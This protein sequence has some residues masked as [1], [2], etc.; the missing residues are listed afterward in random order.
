[1]ANSKNGQNSQ[2]DGNG[3]EAL[4][5]AKEDVGVALDKAKS[6]AGKA[7]EAQ[8]EIPKGI[9]S[10]DTQCRIRDILQELVISAKGSE[11]SN[12]KVEHA[13]QK[14]SEV[15]QEHV[16][17]LLKSLAKEGK[18]LQQ[19]IENLAGTIEEIP[20]NLEHV[21]H[22][23][24]S[25]AVRAARSAG[26]FLSAHFSHSHPL[27]PD[28]PAGTLGS[29]EIYHSAVPASSL[30]ELAN[31]KRLEEVQQQGGSATDRQFDPNY[32]PVEEICSSHSSP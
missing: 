22:G 2:S 31:P 1:L 28:L 7:E 13:L 21:V 9:I 26:S 18:S 29:R 6:V 19:I 24:E 32:K 30:A 16:P 5:Q 12:L 25:A 11:D 23:G 15:H 8:Q 14:I 27:S 10:E 17:S 20:A 4:G 3:Q